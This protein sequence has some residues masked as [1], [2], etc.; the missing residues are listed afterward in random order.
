MD[1]ID[2]VLYVPLDAV[3]DEGD[4]SYVY[5]K[6]GG[7]YDKVEVET[8]ASNSDFIVITKGLES[9]D[10]VALVDPYAAEKTKENKATGE[11]AKEGSL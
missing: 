11:T 6:S 10:N 9:G 5:K 7:G 1:K 8:G 2:D 3:H 4:K